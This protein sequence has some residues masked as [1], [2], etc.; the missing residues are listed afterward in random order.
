MYTQYG[1]VLR[2][3]IILR[4][5][6]FQLHSSRS[7]FIPWIKYWNCYDFADIYISDML[8]FE[9]L[10]S[11]FYSFCVHLVSRTRWKP[12]NFSNKKRQLPWKYVLST[13]SFFVS[14]NGWYLKQSAGM[15]WLYF[16]L[17]TVKFLIDVLLLSKSER[18]GVK[19]QLLSLMFKCD[20]K[21]AES[22]KCN[23]NCW[24]DKIASWTELLF[25][26]RTLHRL[27]IYTLMCACELS[28][29]SLRLLYKI[30]VPLST[31]HRIRKYFVVFWFYLCCW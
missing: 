30:T 22:Q 18:L 26:V 11:Q 3:F 7:I 24:I 10:L 14:T 13:C 15:N 4:N 31:K 12:S 9:I 23:I 8:L 2:F 20:S 17:S 5:S 21:I 29:V 16:N 19:K 6:H 28:Q 1:L 25:A 27:S